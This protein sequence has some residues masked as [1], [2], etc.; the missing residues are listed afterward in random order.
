MKQRVSSVFREGSIQDKARFPGWLH[1]E[2]NPRVCN[3]QGSL[4]HSYWSSHFGNAPSLAL[5]D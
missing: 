1:E 2:G 4:N 3:F 5:P